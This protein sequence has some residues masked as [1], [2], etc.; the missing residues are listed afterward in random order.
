MKRVRA[1][2]SR[3]LEALQ[4]H[5]KR[6]RES[7]RT[8]ADIEQ[9]ILAMETDVAPV[10]DFVSALRRVRDIDEFK[11]LFDAMAGDTL[12]PE[13]SQII[14]GFMRPPA[15]MDLTVVVAGIIMGRLPGFDRVE[16]YR[17]MDR[18]WRMLFERDFQSA[19]DQRQLDELYSD[20]KKGDRS[21]DD[22]TERFINTN[23]PRRT[24]RA[25]P[26]VTNYI[27]LWDR[28][29]REGRQEDFPYF[30]K[31]VYL[32][33]NTFF[34][35]L[36]DLFSAKYPLESAKD[37]G[38]PFANH[39]I[40]RRDTLR[41]PYAEAL[42]TEST[43]LLKFTT[44]FDNWAP[45]SRKTAVQG[46]V[47]D[48]VQ[49][50]IGPPQRVPGE[51]YGGMGAT[52]R[53]SYREF[54]DSAV[55]NM[56]QIRSDGYLRLHEHRN[57]HHIQH[58]H[59]LALAIGTAASETTYQAQVV[60]SRV[61]PY[62]KEAWMEYGG[63][64]YVGSSRESI[65]SYPHQLRR[66]LARMQMDFTPI[67]PG[68]MAVVKPTTTISRS[69]PPPAPLMSSRVRSHNVFIPV[70]PGTLNE[71][72]SYAVVTN[73]GPAIAEC[74]PLV[75][76]GDDVPQ[77]VRADFKEKLHIPP[78]GRMFLLYDRYA[79]IGFRTNFTQVDNLERNEVGPRLVHIAS[80]EPPPVGPT[81]DPDAEVVESRHFALRAIDPVAWAHW[82]RYTALLE[83]E[84]YA[85][86]SDHPSEDYWDTIYNEDNRGIINFMLGNPVMTPET[87]RA[88]QDEILRRQVRKEFI[89]LVY[90]D[91]SP[92]Y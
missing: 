81:D 75:V 89:A 71:E 4:R 37:P 82:L 23:F 26:N 52:L 3:A 85:T 86:R 16:I 12:M 29:G 55:A 59:A 70:Y 64:P 8:D 60:F 45:T 61:L 21:Y 14:L 11:A 50:Q 76:D 62:K 9:L 67:V 65:T 24:T 22:D 18:F 46:N 34:R 40:E 2:T 48:I 88:T 31:S 69:P 49:V 53:T 32:K 27:G 42:H 7:G 35:K 91:D 20:V 33:S 41:H 17:Y 36:L 68:Q 84:K 74:Q 90:A 38:V 54:L 73:L 77:P 44:V 78:R 58:V 83:D 47:H 19:F 92:F 66:G 80:R 87:M 6:F 63:Q 25:Y 10:A 15:L 57:G 72:D 1:E 39:S 43:P 28:L 13:L 51:T 56:P 30:W 79:S 5:A